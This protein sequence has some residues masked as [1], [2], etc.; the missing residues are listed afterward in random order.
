MPIDGFA[1][2]RSD[3]QNDGNRRSWRDRASHMFTVFSEKIYRDVSLSTSRRS[4]ISTP[5]LVGF[6]RYDEPPHTVPE[7][8]VVH[9]T[10]DLSIISGTTYYSAVSRA[11]ARSARIMP[12][13][14]RE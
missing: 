10:N 6:E 9:A 4:S 11:S 5:V 3:E 7:S 12:G 2:G 13:Y 8:K 14:L 1:Q